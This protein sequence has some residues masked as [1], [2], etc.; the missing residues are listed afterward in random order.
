MKM[1][2]KNGKAQ[3]G[4]EEIPTAL[5]NLL[6]VIHKGDTVVPLKI[7]ANAYCVLIKEKIETTPSEWPIRRKKFYHDWLKNRFLNSFDD[8]IEQL[9][10]DNPGIRSCVGILGRRF[11]CME[12]R[13]TGR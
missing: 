2:R 5:S 7:V 8:F 10:K 1:L 11:S 4:T 9:Q 13:A 6:E 3:Q 12:I